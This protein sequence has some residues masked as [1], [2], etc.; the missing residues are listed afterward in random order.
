M[1]KTIRNVWDKNLSYEKLMKAHIE[2]KKGKT[3][4]KEISL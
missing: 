4:R 1:P 2:S 3:S